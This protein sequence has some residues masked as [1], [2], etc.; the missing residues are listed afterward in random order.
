M[1]DGVEGAS[2]HCASLR[3]GIP[4]AGGPAGHVILQRGDLCRIQPVGEEDPVGASADVVEGFSEPEPVE[5]GVIGLREGEQFLFRV[6]PLVM[7]AP[8]SM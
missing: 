2:R 6:R 1:P 7:M 5:A 8:T 4:D 3:G